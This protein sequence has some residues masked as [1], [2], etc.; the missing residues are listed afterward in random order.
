MHL[1]HVGRRHRPEQRAVLDVEPHF[2]SDLQAQAIDTQNQT[3]AACSQ[4]GCLYPGLDCRYV[5]VLPSQGK[6]RPFHIFF[7]LEYGNTT[8]RILGNF[9]VGPRGL[10][11]EFD[12]LSDQR[13]SVRIQTRNRLPG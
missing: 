13:E 6:D 10:C 4:D 1:F 9:A 11:L 12:H 5:N 7:V 3:I 2:G 8:E